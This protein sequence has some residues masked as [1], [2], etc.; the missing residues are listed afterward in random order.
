MPNLKT[1][2]ASGAST[3][4]A[5]P[6][7]PV[8]SG[9]N[10]G[11]HLTGAGPESHGYLGNGAKPSL[12]PA[13]L[14][15]YG[16]FPGIFGLVRD[17][18]P[19]AETGAIYDWAR[20]HELIEDKAVTYE[21]IVYQS[22]SSRRLPAHVSVG[23]YEE[24]T[25]RTSVDAANY[26][27]TKKPFFTFVYFGAPD[28]TGH[29][30]GHDTPAYYATLKKCDDHIGQLLGAL[31]TAGIEKETIVIVVSDHGGL[32]KGHG[33]GT[34]QGMQTPWIIAGPGVK[35]GHTLVPGIVHYD[36]TP[37]IAHILGI[38]PPPTFRGRPALDAFAAKNKN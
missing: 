30:I 26:I 36:T 8:I 22:R 28:E 33:E 38:S 27:A 37:T 2:A 23:I 25:A 18:Y 21:R 3:L 14:S 32:G 16:R 12:P 29:H 5:R 24:S 19:N 35:R 13:V 15:K 20:I 6:I 7:M 1:L 4:K 10:W 34:M 11:A 9:P 17:A 31:K